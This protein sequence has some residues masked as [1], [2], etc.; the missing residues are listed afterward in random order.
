MFLRWFCR[1]DRIEE[2]EGDL[3]E[4]FEKQ[5]E[6]SPRAAK[7]R[8]VWDVIKSLRPV[9]LKTPF[10]LRMPMLRNY[11]KTGHRHLAQDY[12]FS[13]LNMIG[14]SMG[15]AIF[16]IMI[17]MVHHELTYDRFHKK[18]DR[19]FQVIQEFHGPQGLDPEIWT[20][21]KL[22][23]AL[24]EEMP[25]VENAVSVHNAASTW[26][27]VHGKRFF[28]EG[29][30]V[31]GPQF[32]D[33]FDFSLSHGNP[34]NVL[35]QSRSIVIGEHLAVKLFGDQNPIGEVIDLEAYGLFT[36]TG[37]LAPIPSNSFIRFDFILTQDYE[38]YFTNVAP[39]F[40]NWFMSWQGDPTGTFVLLKDPKDEALLEEGIKRVLS[41]NIGDENAINRHYAIN[42]YD[43]HFGLN[44]VDGQLNAF[45]K[46]DMGQ[47][48][49]FAVIALL[50][51]AMACFNYVNIATARSLRRTKEVGVRKS[52]GARKDQ[53][54]TQFLTESFLLVI[55]SFIVSAGLA[56][57]T[58]PYFNQITGIDITLTWEM[59]L[60]IMPYLLLTVAVVTVFA[61]FYPAVV[62][63]RFS[64]IQV[65]KN[66]IISVRGNNILR[67]ILVT[68]QFM[69]VTGMLGLLLVISQQYH[70]LNNRSMGFDTE[71]LVVVEINW[72]D[73][74][75]NFDQI[76]RELLSTP[77]IADVT[78]L[79]RM[80][81][82]PRGSA[83]LY[84]ATT[85]DPERKWR[86][87]FYGMDK[88][89]LKTVG[90][91]LL[92]GMN[93]TGTYSFDSASVLLN[94][95]GAAKFGGINALGKHLEISVDEDFLRAKVV[96]IVQD[97]HYESFHDEI[98]PV[99]IGHYNNMFQSLDDIVIRLAGGDIVKSLER[100]ENIHN[101]Y[102]RND[103]MTWGF[104]D[105]MIQR[106]YEKELVY[107][108]IFTGSAIASLIIAILGVIGTLSYNIAN[109]T[110]EFGI[111]KVL[112]ASFVQLLIL[113]SKDVIKFIILS[114]AVAIP[115][116]W[117][118]ASGWLNSFSYRI[119]LDLFPFLVV[120]ASITIT[121]MAIIYLIGFRV[122]RESPV[123]SLRDE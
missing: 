84:V 85:E 102:D 109:R 20:S 77:G 37:V 47:V 56:M 53:L 89:G 68:I 63:S 8:F 81:G 13:L 54:R 33:I 34:E 2:I 88:D 52:I 49:V 24:R 12:R 17:L 62:L 25:I 106:A 5:S 43:L 69:M 71:Q 42:L 11:V 60:A 105:D 91:E 78:G 55:I 44:G 27:E 117:M 36:V 18:G 104:M 87:R 114:S 112:G 93:F 46:G 111:R 61:G 10:Q 115:V 31:A 59:I 108:K 100:I 48:R 97:F 95:T 70:Y 96:G 23:E 58:L 57:I 110:K 14:L 66:S 51:L 9:N 38:D 7:R 50:V 74:R 113:Q 99:V 1:E 22:S 6:L 35:K 75:N 72:V 21:M 101:K 94:E 30:I 98:G 76:K 65:L 119:R 29:G 86:M 28:E 45:V 79:T 118:L 16:I 123:K 39:W 92:H 122:A 4:L 19:I 116:T 67:N 40:P 41:K 82:G 26:F 3:I 90:L 107:R 83:N 64:A 120:V 73:V 32:F 15:L 80:M 121:A 103:V